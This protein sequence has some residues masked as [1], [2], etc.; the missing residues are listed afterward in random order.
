[1]PATLCDLLN[2]GMRSWGNQYVFDRPRLIECLQQAGFARVA[3]VPWR[4][5]A[6][7]ALQNLERRPFHGDLIVEAQK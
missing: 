4:Q 5:S 1:V 3:S 7:P 6:L 2:E